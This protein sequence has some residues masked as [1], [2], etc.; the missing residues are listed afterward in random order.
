MSRPVTYL[1]TCM[2]IAYIYLPSYLT[3]SATG[4]HGDVVMVDVTEGSLKVEFC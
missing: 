3:Q 4:G 1:F 2:H